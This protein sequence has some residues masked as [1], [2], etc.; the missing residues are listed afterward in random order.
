MISLS[1]SNPFIK[2][3][4]YGA[5]L[6]FL[7]GCTNSNL[8]Y[9]SL[10]ASPT[11]LMGGSG[12][13]SPD[14]FVISTVSIAN[15]ANGTSSSATASIFFDTSQSTLNALVSNHCNVSSSNSNQISK[16][17]LC[18][19]S[20]TEINPNGGNSS[21]IPRKTTTPVSAVQAS[22]IG[23]PAPS[24][25]NTEIRD[26]TQL[27]I[28]VIAAPGNGDTGLFSV[29]PIAY[30]KNT[31]TVTG[32]FQDSQGHI[33]DNILHYACYQKFMRGMS[34]Q[35]QIV[36]QTNSQTSETAKVLV[37]TKFCV[38]S[39]G[40]TGTSASSTTCPNP[41]SPDYSAQANYFNLYIRN[42]ERGDINQFN[43]EF[44]C[45]MVTESLNSVAGSL[46]TQSQP[47]PLDTQFA[48]SLSPTSTFAVGVVS[49]SKLSIGSTPSS[50]NSS[51]F[52]T[53]SSSTSS[54][55]PSPDAFI[56]SCL[57]FAANVNS[58]GT[59]PSIKDSSGLIRPTFRLRRFITI[60]PRVY[61]TGGK[62]IPKRMQGLD[63]IYV[64]DRPVKGPPQSNPQKPYTMLGPK[65][66]PAA[67][68][69][70]KGVI[71]TGYIPTSYT[72]WA[73]KN[74]DGIELPNYDSLPGD[75]KASCSASLPILSQ[76][77]SSWS[78]AT[79]NI[80]N[81]NGFQHI[82]I[83]P[84]QPFIPHYEEDTDFQACAPQASPFQDPP[85]HFSRDPVT[86]RVAWCA[87]SYP[88]QNPNVQAIDPPV[89]PFPQTSA[90]PSPP[91][92]IP[93]GDVS[94]YTSH[95]VKNSSSQI[96][97]GISIQP[98]ATRTYDYSQAPS[99]NK[100]AAHLHSTVWDAGRADQTCDR[101]VTPD[102][103]IAWPR[104]PLLSSAGGIEGS[105][106]QDS[107]Y[108]CLVTYDA[109]GV[110]TNKMTPTDGCCAINAV[111][112]PTGTAGNST[113]HLE[114]DVPC[115]VPNY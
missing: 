66:C 30:T 17:C 77:K 55:T 56:N 32:S 75:S 112:V 42:T 15:S 81:K 80:N 70:R 76:D 101:T 5:F 105:I 44:I 65:P 99:L 10:L 100:Y 69:D 71:K 96:C 87:E 20:W 6:I 68:F 106:N 73:G 57:G 58:D 35:N 79:V 98:L 64:L 89:Q 31:I 82:Y 102:P 37:G 21:S 18:Q 38:A 40:S 1:Q 49:N 48:L 107:S 2:L 45:P 84:I 61:D 95:V 4:L 12:T 63:T 33:F 46:A 34:I 13:P 39:S 86:G 7:T 59:C 36:V 3:I 54:S 103:G 88:T 41:A 16:P 8:Q 115:N 14:Q 28:S 110:K 29:T 52:P 11:S 109:Q 72:G 91:S 43:N 47:W 104:F 94:P 97:T 108:M 62:T 67:Y 93:S 50:Q 25:Y 53:A 114:P 27:K 90:S 19:F 113:A 24:I 22:F 74:V 60:Y 26:G 9:P 51:C 85:L 78:I 92:I 23:C 83:R 111:S